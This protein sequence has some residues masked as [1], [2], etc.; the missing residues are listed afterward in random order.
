MDDNEILRRIKEDDPRVISTVYRKYHGEFINFV[1]KGF[2]KLNR[3][4]AE[5]AYNECFQA[6]YRNVKQGKLVSLK[7]EL[8]TYLFQIGKYKVVDELNRRTKSGNNKN[9]EY[10]PPEEMLDLDYFEEKDVQTKKTRL[11][12][13]V[14]SKLTDPCKSLLILFW[15]QE[16]SDKEIVASTAYGSTETVKNQRSRC[17][18]TLKKIYLDEL[19]SENMITIS[20][21]QR[22]IGE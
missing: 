3:E 1:R 4:S 13:E 18:K 19:V 5:D 9:I 2:P 15:Y 12:D 22:L 16:K 14:V 10:L 21:K 17:M 11:L 8:K 20:E 7:C 6:L